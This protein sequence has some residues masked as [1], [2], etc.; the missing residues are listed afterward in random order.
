MAI[1]SELDPPVPGARGATTV[2]EVIA[3]PPGGV[4]VTVT[5]LAAPVAVAP[6]PLA[7]SAVTAVCTRKGTPSTVS[8]RS[9][10]I[11]PAGVPPT[12]PTL[13]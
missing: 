2:L 3:S 13:A 6:D 10:E 4:T 1:T 12:V 11:V 7:A 9:G 8:V 5:R